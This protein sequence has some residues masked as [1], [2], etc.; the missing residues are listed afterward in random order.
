MTRTTKPR[1]RRWSWSTMNMHEKNTTEILKPIRSAQGWSHWRISMLQ[2]R[3][4]SWAYKD[5][6]QAQKKGAYSHSLHRIGD[7]PLHIYRGSTEV[8]KKSCSWLCEASQAAKE[9]YLWYTNRS[10]ACNRYAVLHIE[11]PM[12]SMIVRIFGRGVRQGNFALDKHVSGLVC[13]TSSIQ[14]WQETR[15]SERYLDYM[16][17]QHNLLLARDQ[18]RR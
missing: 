8:E 18:L 16:R 12:G 10:A 2:G 4:I 6:P 5:D 17:R 11:K 14:E 3:M 13:L 15:F 9:V 7:L 1:T